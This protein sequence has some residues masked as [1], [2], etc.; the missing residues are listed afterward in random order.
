MKRATT[1]S[2]TFSTSIWIGFEVPQNLLVRGKLLGVGIIP[3]ARIR[4][5]QLPSLYPHTRI[6]QSAVPKIDVSKQRNRT[7]SPFLRTLLRALL[8]IRRRSI[9]DAPFEHISQS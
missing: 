3:I 2:M 7:G 6:V 4:A 5:R 1:L 9:I 8:R